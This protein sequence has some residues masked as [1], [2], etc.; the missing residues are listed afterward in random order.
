MSI[1]GV[2]EQRLRDVYTDSKVL[3]ETVKSMDAEGYVFAAFR[4]SE[5][6]ETWLFSSPSY[7]K[8]GKYGVCNGSFTC[9]SGL[10]C[11]VA[12]F[13]KRTPPK[14]MIVTYTETEYVPAG[15]T[16]L[17]G[18]IYYDDTIKPRM[19]RVCN[20]WFIANYP[21][22]IFSSSIKFVDQQQGE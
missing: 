3:D 5:L 13:V 1:S 2:Y 16:V 9:S 14:K 18:S 21:V 12:I 7:I 20:T 4:P 19:L 6:G 11:P 17:R 15:Q 10:T 8:N 22:R